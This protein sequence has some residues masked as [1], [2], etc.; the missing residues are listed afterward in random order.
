VDEVRVS[1]WGELNEELFEGAWNEGLGRFRANHVFRGMG[2]STCDLSTSLTRLGGDFAAHEGHLLRNFRKYAHRDAVGV[3]SAWHWLALAQHHG[4]PTRLL[5][6]SFSPFVALHMAT[7]NPG[8][9]DEDGVVWRLDY[10]LT[11]QKLPKPLQD[12]LKEENPPR[13]TSGSSINSPSSP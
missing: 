6:W 8:W 2:R 12:V 10:L 13:S 9:F 11:N 4:L 7:E 1:N 3:D 5:D